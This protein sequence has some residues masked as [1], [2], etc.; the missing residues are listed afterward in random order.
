MSNVQSGES[1][2]KMYI[3]K[4]ETYSAYKKNF[5]FLILGANLVALGGNVF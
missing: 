1:R 2:E 4:R 5:G 3:R